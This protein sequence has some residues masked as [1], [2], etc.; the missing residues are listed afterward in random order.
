[1]S[2]VDATP[3]AAGRRA[4]AQVDAAAATSDMPMSLSSPKIRPWHLQRKAVVYIRQSTPQQV[5]D[6]RESAD[7]QYG[8]V[9]RA[10]ALGWPPDA[11]DVVD[12][13]QGRSGQTVEGRLGF[14]YLLAEISLDHVGIVFGLEMSRLARSNKD[15]HQ[16]LE[17]CA[18]FRTLLADQDG[19][20]DP[21]DY[22]DRLLLGL[23]GTMSEAELHVLRSRMYQGLRHSS[24]IPTVN[25]RL[26]REPE[27]ASARLWQPDPAGQRPRR[28]HAS[29][30]PTPAARSGAPTSFAA[31]CSAAS[32]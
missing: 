1:M 10:A 18:I 16:L 24:L 25:Q 31:T 22:N 12:E 15:W 2:H 9:H 29:S 26:W 27:A 3:T 4:E 17:L 21:T 20:Y 6:H 8:L 13:D 11:V 5:L 23:K 14:Q 32:L 7:R 19:L 28:P 30:G